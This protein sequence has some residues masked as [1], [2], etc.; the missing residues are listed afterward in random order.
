MA[1]TSNQ[2]DPENPIEKGWDD[3]GFKRIRYIVLVFLVEFHVS[4]M[5]KNLRSGGVCRWWAL[6]MGQMQYPIWVV[7]SFGGCGSQNFVATWFDMV[8]SYW[9]GDSAWV[10]GQGCMT[11]QVRGQSSL[12]F[13]LRLF[14][15]E[16]LNAR[17]TDTYGCWLG[18]YSMSI[19]W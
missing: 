9:D 6:D 5:P 16:H 19:F 10:G 2:S 7:Q 11:I 8:P 15:R 12:S 14:S 1:G 18:A 4:S 3:A 13:C 17:S